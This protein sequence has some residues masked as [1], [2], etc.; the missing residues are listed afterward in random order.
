MGNF[1]TKNVVVDE[2]GGVGFV[3]SKKKFKKKL[4]NYLRVPTRWSWIRGMGYGDNWVTFYLDLAGE[5]ESRITPYTSIQKLKATF[6]QLTTAVSPLQTENRETI[7]RSA[8]AV[9]PRKL[10]RTR[11]R[12]SFSSYPDNSPGHEIH[13]RARPQ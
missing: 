7:P 4:P 1:F 5:E 9:G 10:G 3:Y 12:F 13:S 6:T 2:E 11:Q 8:R